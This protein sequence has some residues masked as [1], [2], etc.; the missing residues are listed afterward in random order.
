MR[1]KNGQ[2]PSNHA[3]EPCTPL[4]HN[5]CACLPQPDWDVE[6]EWGLK[7]KDMNGVDR[8]MQASTREPKP[9]AAPNPFDSLPN[10]F[11]GGPPNPFGGGPPKGRVVPTQ[12]ESAPAAAA[13]KKMTLEER[14]MAENA[15]KK[16]KRKGF[17]G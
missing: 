15:A 2:Q 14:L 10:P 17:F 5:T 12:Q 11:G 7:R 6:V 13:P 3:V 16:S 9:K 8:Q 1:C 4:R